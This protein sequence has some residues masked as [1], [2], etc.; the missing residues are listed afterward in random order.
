MLLERRGGV[1]VVEGRAGIGKTSLVEAAL[2]RADGLGYEVVR[3]RGSELE[4][5]FAFGVGASCSNGDWRA[6]QRLS[7]RR[8]W[9]A[10][11]LRRRGSCC[12]ASSPRS[13]LVIFRSRYCMACTGWWLTWRIKSAPADRR[14]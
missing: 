12:T 7:V 14:R 4:A 2:L 10:L 11:L 1:L 6:R 9:L 5:G 13:L 8:C 3:A